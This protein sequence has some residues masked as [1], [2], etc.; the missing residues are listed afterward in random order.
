MT[1]FTNVKRETFFPTI[2]FG[3]N[4][5]GKA[6]VKNNYVSRMG[7]RRISMR[8]LFFQ[9]I[10]EIMLHKISVSWLILIHYTI[11]KYVSYVC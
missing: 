1:G 3:N 9:V 11:N 7:S 5:C 8:E 2:F 4:C 6:K 10:V